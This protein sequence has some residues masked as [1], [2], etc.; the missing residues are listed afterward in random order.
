[1]SFTKEKKEIILWA[2][3]L[4]KK[5]Y[6]CARG[7]NI[8]TRL[9]RD[10]ILITAHDCYLGFLEEKDIFLVD[11]AREL[12]CDKDKFSSERFLHLGIHKEYSETGVVIHAHCP[13]TTAFFNYFDKLEIF[14]FETKFYLGDIAIIPQETPTVSD[15]TPVIKALGNGSI[16]VLKNH[17]VVA[18]GEDFKQVF[19]LI[20]LLEEQAKVNLL[21][22]NVVSPKVDVSLSE[23]ALQQDSVCPAERQKLKIYKMLSKEHIDKLA[24]IVNGDK[25]VQDL[26][27]KYNLT[28]TLAVKNQDT[29][30]AVC[31]YYQQGR[32]VKTDNSDNA[33]F[34]IIGRGEMLKR[35]FNKEVDPF[36][37]SAQGK[38]KTKGDFAKMGRWY[39]VMVRTFK[40]WEQAP[41]E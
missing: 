17:G 33:E 10:K 35:V 23:K 34:V 1:M 39:P 5:G 21:I 12:P 19:S 2:R 26:G 9:P 22:K 11:L 16:V 15:T 25:E 20:E 13:Y 30:D 40:L 3:R 38:V 4:N 18:V 6:V 31:F 37:A 36:V 27:H 41:V 24:E 32:I 28:C 29:D 14:S 8:S 7:G